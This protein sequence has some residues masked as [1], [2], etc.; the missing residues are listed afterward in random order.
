[1]MNQVETFPASPGDYVRDAVGTLLSAVAVLVAATSLF[2]V[3]AHP[4]LMGTALTV[5][6][7]AVA[8]ALTRALL[9]KVAPRLGRGL[10]ALVP[11]V[12][13]WLAAIY[14]LVVVFGG[15]PGAWL[16]TGAGLRALGGHAQTA[17]AAFSLQRI[18]IE[19]T[20]AVVMVVVAGAMLALILT[21]LCAVALRKPLLAVVPVGAL[22]APSLALT[23]RVA[24]GAL[25]G[26]V[27]C[28]VALLATRQGRTLPRRLVRRAARQFDTE[29]LPSVGGLS[30]SRVGALPSAGSPSVASSFAG[31]FADSSSLRVLPLARRRLPGAATATTAVTALV[32]TALAVGAGL[33]VRSNPHPDPWSFAEVYESVNAGGGGGMSVGHEVEWGATLGS[34]TRTPVFRYTTQTG[35]RL[36]VLR[37]T[38]FSTFDVRAN[39]W[40]MGQ[41]S[42]QST[43]SY[44]T[45]DDWSYLNTP[46]YSTIFFPQGVEWRSTNGGPQR[47]VVH[48]GHLSEE[49]LPRTESGEV[50]WSVLDDD[51]IW[52][53]IEWDP[54]EPGVIAPRH[55][56]DRVT[57]T[58]DALQDVR[59]PM[60]IEPFSFVPRILP[61]VL[62]NEA[63]GDAMRRDRTERGEEIL[64]D[65]TARNMDSV[66]LNMVTWEHMRE[67][68]PAAGLVWDP[69]THTN[70]VP[71]LAVP[72]GVHFQDIVDYTARIVD[73][74][75]A[76][77]P[78]ET[79][80]AIQN[81]LADPTRFSYQY[82]PPAVST[83]DPVWDF[84]QY[85]AGYCVHFATA[86]TLMA[87]TQ[88][89]PARMAVGF[90]PGEPTGND[91][92]FVV[93]QRDA[94]AWPELHF[95]GF[96][97]V[98]FEPTTSSVAYATP[99][100]SP[101]LAED[102]EPAQQETVA[103]DADEV[104]DGTPDLA[105]TGADAATAD[106]DDVSHDDRSLWASVA[107]LP[108]YAT[109][110]AG[111]L[112][113]GIFAVILA[114][115]L[116]GVGLRVWARRRRVDDD[117]EL[118]WLRA[119]HVLA[120][121]GIGLPPS[122]TPLQAPRIAEEAWQLKHGQPMPDDHRDSLATAAARLE[123]A[124][125]QP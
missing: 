81:Y 82:D 42:G 104:E 7:V 57:L 27:A 95:P 52:D 34:R 49:L 124:R 96:G 69:G 76:A 108:W 46:G 23:G 5:M 13:G 65:M 15:P 6:L 43:D 3:I 40:S 17:L 36:D 122:A 112:I 113:A 59:V 92:E 2:P 98:R 4:W 114:G 102:Y 30:V 106:G 51:N 58:I 88:G 90:L 109:A 35:N 99:E 62:Y 22:W 21:D 29:I 50:D 9:P 10:L 64:F 97:W 31:S 111:L 28:L 85:R 101:Q 117:A 18:P 118:T 44:Q 87:R 55:A 8:C 91:N 25:A 86:M 56:V 19:P 71:T 110:P 70:T 103:A 72:R 116:L 41:S 24:P 32:V 77:T 94:H 79:A 125:Y 121:H 123:A 53:Y 39:S 105:D 37:V 14:L 66:F 100:H 67:R 83:G 16:P 68:V 48:G 84:L 63:R 12:G 60:P 78:F 75:G 120:R 93:R 45:L 73:D 33:L 26:T 11:T 80:V 107:D 47:P 38:S 119:L 20:H 115:A 74:A 1:M 89:I 54:W 61:G